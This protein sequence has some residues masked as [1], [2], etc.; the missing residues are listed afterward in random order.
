MDDNRTGKIIKGITKGCFEPGL[1]TKLSIPDNAFK[2]W[3]YQRDD[4]RRR[5]QL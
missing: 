2:K 1:E 5:C 4:Y 3:V